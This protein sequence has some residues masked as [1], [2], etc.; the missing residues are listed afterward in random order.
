MS[1][2]EAIVLIGASGFIGRNVIEALR[3]RVEL[4]IG[5]TSQGHPV[6]GCVQT[7]GM[8]NLDLVPILPPRTV[9]VNVAAFR[10]RASLFANKQADILSTNVDLVDRV[11]RFALARDIKEVRAASSS[12]VY[13]AAW[14]LLDDARPLDLNAWP[15]AG[16]S[17]YA[18]SKRWGEIVGDIWHKCAG[19]NTISFRLTNPY[20]RFDTLKEGEAH[21]ATAFVIRALG[22]EQEFAIHGDPEAERD[23]VFAGDVGASFVSSLKLQG[24]HE[25]VNC[26][27]GKSTRMIDLAS[28]ALQAAGKTRPLRINPTP[29]GAN[30]GIAA[31]RA[32]ARR[33]HDLLPDLPPFCT[34]AEGM[35]ATV[36]W[37]RD[38]L[39]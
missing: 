21:V 16:E 2:P 23:F 14:E 32:T 31:R 25:A 13:P 1:L 28:I 5:V 6:P 37:Y 4:L 35:R 19:I 9:I 7:F 30:T 27:T 38:A 15:H 26:A 24:V 18:W 29:A 10:Y 8:K 34:L 36:D 20:G 12:A 3:G 33:L 17:A 22:E 11:Y 39:R